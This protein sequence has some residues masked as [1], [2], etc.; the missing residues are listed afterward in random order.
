M[1]ALT[2]TQQYL[3]RIQPV[4]HTMLTDGPTAHEAEIVAR[5]FEYLQQHVAQGAVLHAGRTLNTDASAFG[6]VILAATTEAKALEI[7]RNDPAVALGVMHVTGLAGYV[8]NVRDVG[9]RLL[10]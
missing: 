2:A 7:M 4:R 10:P 8:V 6:I 3:Y 9:Y 1:L 5:H